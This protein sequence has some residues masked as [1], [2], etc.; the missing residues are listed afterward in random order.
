MDKIDYRKRDDSL[1]KT[2]VMLGDLLLCNVLFAFACLIN[3]L[4]EGAALLQSHL[5]ITGCNRT[6]SSPLCTS[7]AR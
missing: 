7:V 6:C 2:L 4:H 5:L 1:I 3:G